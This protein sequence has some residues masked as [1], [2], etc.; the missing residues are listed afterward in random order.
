ELALADADGLHEHAPETARV[1]EVDERTHRRGEPSE[2]P[3][4]RD[5]SDEHTVV[6]RVSLHAQSIAEHG[7]AAERRRWI[8]GDDADQ[9]TRGAAGGDETVD[10]RALSGS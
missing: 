10:E 8:D 6:A 2:V 9:V 7:A 5:R 1:V 3:P 4:V